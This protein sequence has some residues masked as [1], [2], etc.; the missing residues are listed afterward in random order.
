MV[1]GTEFSK[2]YKLFC[3]VDNN[4]K[5]I[6]ENYVGIMYSIKIKYVETW[7][8]IRLL[9]YYRLDKIFMM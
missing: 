4:Q 6:F 1:K 3:V 5:L 9:N 7:L 8:Y 2:Y